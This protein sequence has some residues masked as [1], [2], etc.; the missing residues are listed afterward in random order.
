[1]FLIMKIKEQSGIKI[2]INLNDTIPER[3]LI[4]VKSQ[5]QWEHV[6][7]FIQ[8]VIQDLYDFN[9]YERVMFENVIYLTYLLVLLLQ[10]FIVSLVYYV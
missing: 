4:N 7:E 3:F 10:D 1:M 2:R 9:K 8:H 6:S 5:R